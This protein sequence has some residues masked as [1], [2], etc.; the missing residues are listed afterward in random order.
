MTRNIRPGQTITLRAKFVDDLGDAEQASNVYVNIFEPDTD[1][2]NL[3]EA[4]VVSGV[5][6]YFGNGIF[7]YAYLVPSNGPA[8]TWTDQWQGQ[9]TSQYLDEDLNFIVTTSGL[10]QDPGSQLHINNIVEVT[11]TSGIN[12]V[13]GNHLKDGFSFS[14]LTTTSPSYTDILKVK[15]EAGGWIGDLPDDVIQLAILEASLEA[16]VITFIKGSPTAFYV[17]ARR[18][19]TTCKALMMLLINMGNGMLK[20]KTLDNLSVTYDT[21]GLVDAMDKSMQCMLKWEGQV[22]A[23]GGLRG[24]GQPVGV[25][26]GACDPDRPNVGR[27][28]IST[29]NGYGPNNVPAAND[30]VKPYRRSYS[31]FNPNSKFRGKKYW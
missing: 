27:L 4:I 7:Q 31:I 8:G 11:L 12:D 14:F 22:I 2:S 10:I 6:N 17:H 26:K 5:A 25:V 16:D 1:T 13:S 19:W 21:A 20:S 28:W 3:S 30:K 9:L 29:D 23:G 15:I 18:E 24:T